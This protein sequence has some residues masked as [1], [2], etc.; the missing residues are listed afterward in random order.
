MIYLVFIA[1]LI[2]IV[3]LFCILNKKEEP[4]KEVKKRGHAKMPTAKFSNPLNPYD[5]YKNKKTQL[6]EPRTPGRGIKIE[7]EETDDGR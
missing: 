5:I 4:K 1:E 2:Q 7:V 6:Y 3:L